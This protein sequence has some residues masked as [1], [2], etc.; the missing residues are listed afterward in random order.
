MAP[1]PNFLKKVAKAIDKAAK[2]LAPFE[3]HPVGKKYIGNLV[4]Q[5][6]VVRRVLDHDMHERQSS[7]QSLSEL[8]RRV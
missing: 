1:D 5:L 4:D 2:E 3:K 7:G 6:A 8:I